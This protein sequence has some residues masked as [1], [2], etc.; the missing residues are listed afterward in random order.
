MEP[1]ENSPV[2]APMQNNKPNQTAMPS[3]MQEQV[4]PGATTQLVQPNQ[5]LTSPAQPFK[6][7]PSEMQS[8]VLPASP[9]ESKKMTSD[10]KKHSKA[11]VVAMISLI[12]VVLVI[13]GVVAAILLNNASDSNEGASTDGSSEVTGATANGSGINH[14]DT[15]SPFFIDNFDFDS[16]KSFD[17]NTIAINDYRLPLTVDN[18]GE[19]TGYPN[20]YAQSFYFGEQGMDKISMTWDEVLH[21]PLE[22]DS[23]SVP[24]YFD[25]NAGASSSGWKGFT[26]DNLNYDAVTLGNAI[27]RTYINLLVD[28]EN[29]GDTSEQ[30]FQNATEWTIALLEYLGRPNYIMVLHDDKLV[31]IDDDPA[32]HSNSETKGKDYDL[33]YAGNGYFL[34]IDIVENVEGN[35]DLPI[36]R[37]TLTYYG[38][39]YDQYYAW[40]FKDASVVTLDEF[41][42]IRKGK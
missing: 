11:T 2:G 38:M 14:D 9:A 24:I 17:P 3:A 8:P 16:L 25:D 22:F 39:P 1:N 12:V 35:P 27:Q 41:L 13:G 28:L 37:S 7:T 33:I 15:S 10:T 18:L 19:M 20:V 30:E 4:I 42:K 6:I 32:I 40:N 5:I 36:K 29:L 34:A 26:V 23:P 31:S 21:S